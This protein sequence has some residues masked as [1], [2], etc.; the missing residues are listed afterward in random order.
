MSKR[1]PLLERRARETGS[2]SAVIVASLAAIFIALLV[3]GSSPV[4]ADGPM[5]RY[6]G[7]HPLSPH[8]GAFCYIDTLHMHRIPPPDMRVYAVLKGGENLFVG[9]PVALGFEGPKFAYFG[10]HPLAIPGAPELP[11]TF[12]YI[13]GAHYHA[14]PQPSSPTLVQK[15]DVTWYIGPP[16]PAA[17]NRVW[18]NEVRAIQSYKP[19]NVDLTSAPP[20]YHPFDLGLSPPSPA[21]VPPPSPPTKTK[22]AARAAAKVTAQPGARP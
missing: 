6:R 16:P 22:P 13:A 19:P 17:P 4:S 15:D 10:P 21:A 14:A 11:G 8:Q 9:D 3:A 12:C 7:I 1:R 5:S 2:R 20:G 18:I